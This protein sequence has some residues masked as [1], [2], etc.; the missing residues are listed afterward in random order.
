IQR[1]AEGSRFSETIRL[2]AGDAGNRIELVDS[3]DWATRAAALKAIF[4]L[5]ASNGQASYNLGLG[6]IARGNDDS[7]KYEVPSHQWF[8]L[9]DRSGAFGVTVLSGDKYGSDKPDDQ[10]LR[11]TLLYTPEAHNY[12]DQ[13]TQDW[14]HHE[15]RYGLA[16]HAGDFPREQTD[17][18]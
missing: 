6:T 7:K 8:D 3:I 12:A 1:R 4:P 16:A 10:T 18:Q 13:A 17:W 11:L 15:I 14:G 5:T 2:A 9:T